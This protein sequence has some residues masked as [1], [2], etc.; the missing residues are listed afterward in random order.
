MLTLER[1]AWLMDRAFVI[2][3]TNIRVGLD[4]ILGLLPVGGDVLTGLVQ[5]GIVLAALLHYRVPKA[6]AARMAANVLLDILVGSIPF[7]GDVF[8][9]FFKANTRNLQ[10]L[11]QVQEHQQQGKPVPSGP[12]VRYLLLIGGLLGA[13]LVLVLIGFIALIIWV[14]R[15]THP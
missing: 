13:T 5:T 9:V 7:V 11:R 15:V 8:D 14:T 4:A 2:P 3:G 12:S 1:L 6:V 10:L